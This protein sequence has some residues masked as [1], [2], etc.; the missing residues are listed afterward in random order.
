MTAL[1]ARRPHVPFRDSQLTR[2]LQ[3]ALGPGATAVLLL[4][5]GVREAR[6]GAGTAAG[7]GRT[8][9][10]RAP[11]TRPPSRRSPRAP[12]TSAR[13]CARSSSRSEWAAWS[14]GRRGAAGPGARGRPPPS[15]R[16]RRSPGPSAPRRRRRGALPAPGPSPPPPRRP[17]SPR[18]GSRSGQAQEPGV[19]PSA[20]GS[21]KAPCTAAT[22]DLWELP[23]SQTPRAGTPPPRGKEGSAGSADCP[24]PGP[25]PLPYHHL[26]LSPAAAGDP[27]AVGLACWFLRHHNHCPDT[28]HESRH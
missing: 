18:T 27:S 1:R 3:P 16:T 28:K 22:F 10:C 21:G 19:A 24:P 12:R 15:A 8:F 20:G 25:G 26:P 6:G 7:E 2:L 23:G 13:P 4:Q 14:W 17:A 11:P 9:A 5:V